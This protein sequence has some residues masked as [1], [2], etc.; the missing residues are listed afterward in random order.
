MLR[1]LTASNYNLLVIFIPAILSWAFTAF[2]VFFLVDYGLGVFV[3]TP[4]FIGMGAAILFNGREKKPLKSSIG[5]AFI[6]VGIYCSGLLFFAMEGAICILM[7]APLGLL[8]AV[9]GAV[10]GDLL[11]NYRRKSATNIFIAFT[12][13]IPSL[14]GFESGQED[15]EELFSVTTSVIIDR[16]PQTVWDQVIAFNRIEEPTEWLFR[17]GIAYPIHAEIKKRGDSI[18]RYCNFSTGSFIEPITTWKE[19]EL[20]AFSVEATPAPLQEI[21]PYEIEPAHLHGYF[22]S[23][24]GQFRLIALPNGQTKLEGTTWYYH[25]IKPSFYWRIWSNYI[26][27]SIHNRVLQHIR[28]Q[29]ENT[30]AR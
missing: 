14:M 22:V 8:L 19:P 15:R 3:F 16:D 23:K 13:F 27:H 26:I 6:S 10:L 17:A 9:I 2:S 18:I 12:I 20:L 28:R 11:M 30:L 24:K 1:K 5:M 25:K 21:S 4:I 29:A 7:A